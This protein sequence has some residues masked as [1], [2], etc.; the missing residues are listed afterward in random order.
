M[1]IARTFVLNIIVSEKNSIIGKSEKSY[2][3]D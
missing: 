3:E 2:F 1:K